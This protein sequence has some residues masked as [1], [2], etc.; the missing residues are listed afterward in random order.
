MTLQWSSQQTILALVRKI[1]AS[2]AL[3]RSERLARFLDFTVTET[4]AGNADQLKEFVIGVEVF[5]RT[6]DY[7][8][9]LDPI[10]RV[11]AR[12]LRMKLRKYY[13]TEGREDRLRIEFP[14][15]GYVPSFSPYR[16]EDRNEASARHA[17]AVLP[18][19]CDSDPTA[20][21]VRMESIRVVACNTPFKANRTPRDYARLRDQLSVEAVL[22]GSLRAAAPGRVRLAIRLV[23]VRD[24]AYL[25][26]ESF[27]RS[28]SDICS[29]RDAI[30]IALDRALLKLAPPQAAVAT[31]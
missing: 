8:P 31:R 9:R 5:G 22:E 30:S 15:G 19:E 13:E 7:D 16:P 6:R 27:E 21:L 20:A 1:I 18:F 10:V 12:R 26:A 4:L 3:A 14:K 25:W 24:G 11:E 23:D 17:I 28:L 2:R 29:V